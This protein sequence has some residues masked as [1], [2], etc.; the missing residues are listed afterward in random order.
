[1]RYDA[2]IIG[3]GPAGSS[4]AIALARQGRTV[5]IVEKSAFPRS[6]VCGEFISP[7][8]LALLDRLGVGDAVRGLAGP[9]IRRLALFASGPGIE[10]RMPRASAD[11]FGRALGR[12][13]LDTLLLQTAAE[14]GA[15][16]LQPW[17]AVISSRYDGDMAVTIENAGERRTLIAPVLIAAH[18]SWEPGGLP[19]QVKK[20]HRPSD[21]LGFKAHFR[22][23][24]LPHDLMPLL[25][26]PGGYGGM[27]WADQGRMSLSC[28]IRRDQL[29]A[30]RA[31]NRGLP[32]GEA[33]YRHILSNC[34]GVAA[35]LRG[36]SLD[37]GWLAAGPIQPGIRD[38][39]AR[40]VFRVGN[41]AGESHPIIA[42]G[43]SM[44]LQ[45][46]WL[47]ASELAR[48]SD[49]DE[50]GREA[51]GHRYASAW[52]SQ[53]A[54]RIL[55]A[56]ILADLASRPLTAK[57]MRGFVRA[58]PASLFLGAQLSGKVAPVPGVG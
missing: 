53:F 4:A 7:V 12:D 3:G 42:E 38:C 23:S 43:I 55:T 49:W 14:A 10:A 57:L 20:P 52:H 54:L 24:A 33:V 46:G 34:P 36:A 15:T 21:F 56:S 17:Q 47:L 40:G 27:V 48:A 18:G 35:V 45:S 39:Y 29:D 11:P 32:A 30:I 5:A 51:A 26:F 6:K 28:C 9:E 8:N 41:V 31:A 2:I 1:M 58:F 25:A 13:V 19:T 16:V 22:N 50:A 44:A 37:G